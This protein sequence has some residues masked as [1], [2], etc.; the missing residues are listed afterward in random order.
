MKP[1]LAIGDALPA[2]IVIVVDALD[3]CSS[4]GEDVLALLVENAARLPVRFIVTSRPEP[5]IA[6]QMEVLQASSAHRIF[7]LHDIEESFVQE[8]IAAY[9]RHAFQRSTIVTTP[10]D[11]ERLAAYAGSLF[12]VAATTVRYILGHGT[13]ISAS[14]S[15]ERMEAA[16]TMA[17]TGAGTEKQYTTIDSLYKAILERVM[18]QLEDS[19]ASEICQVLWAT[20]CVREP[21]PISTLS[22]I[23]D[24]KEDTVYETIKLLQSVLHV[25]EATR[26]VSTL[27]AS[28]PD[29]MFSKVR[30]G[31]FH[32]NRL[33]HDRR[34]VDRCFDMMAKQLKFNICSIETSHRLDKDIPDLKGRLEE[35]V[36]SE[37]FYAC[38]YWPDHLQIT[39][40]SDETTIPLRRFLYEH[41]L[42]WIEVIN[43]KGWIS[44][45]ADA[46]L[47]ALKWLTDSAPA[48]FS[49]S[50]DLAKLERAIR[51]AQ[52]FVTS[53]A[54]SPVS[55]STPHLYLSSLP[56]SSKHSELFAHHR[57]RFRGLP[58]ELA[59]TRQEA[60]GGIGA[61]AV[62]TPGYSVTSLAVSP[63]GARLASG[64]HGGAIRIWD[65]RL[66]VVILDLV[67]GHPTSTWIS[68]VAFPSS[69]DSL[70]SG[71]LDG[72]ICIWNVA[73]AGVLTQTI[74]QHTGPINTVAFHPNIRMLASASNDGS[75]CLWD[76]HD[77]QQPSL[78]FQF[79]DDSHWD[80]SFSPNGLQLASA[81]YGQSIH[82]RSTETGELMA[83]PLRGHEPIKRVRYTPDGLRIV[84]Y[85][86]DKTVRVWSSHD[87]TL[88]AGPFHLDMD[89][90]SPNAISL[91]PDPQGSLLACAMSDATIQVISTNTG[92]LVSGPFSGHT[93]TIN[94]V[95]FLPT[96]NQLVSASADGTVR[97]WEV[98]RGATQPAI[99]HQGHTMAINSVTVSPDGT[100]VVSGSDDRS[101]CIWDATSGVLLRQIPRAHDDRINSVSFCSDGTKFTSGSSDNTIRIWSPHSG[102]PI[103]H[104]LTGHTDQV[105]T[106]S[107]SS[108]GNQLVSGSDDHTVRV[109][110]LRSDEVSSK[111]LLGHTGWVLSVAFSPDDAWVVSGSED[112]KVGL[113]DARESALIW[114]GSAHTSE[115]N[116]VIFSPD[117]SFVASGSQD[118]M[119]LF[120][121]TCTGAV[122]G[123]PLVGQSLQVHSL[124]FSPDGNTLASGSVHHMISVWDVNTRALRQ[125]FEAYSGVHSVAFL[126]DGRHIISGQKDGS[127]RK[128]DTSVLSGSTDGEAASW[129]AR[130]DGWVNNQKSRLL[131]WLP[132]D[133]RVRMFLDPRNVLAIIGGQA[134]VPETPNLDDFHFGDTWQECY[135]GATA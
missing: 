70:A 13:V 105:W 25:S 110:D 73:T 86:Q 102:E 83:D 54:A 108:N 74:K 53:F 42:L 19:E 80:V 18:E 37:L 122:I 92:Q 27:H 4:G 125:S 21:A 11:I 114:M 68:A 132:H 115:V 118:G 16:L 14:H 67:G 17:R 69:G 55:H 38:R 134:I 24:M 64:S 20:L 127:I 75:V 1:L 120:W 29:F 43:L 61:L 89:T 81:G 31:R 34:L 131:V 82:I 119:V 94:S 96:G 41:L 88:L 128:W 28:F 10:H 78:R 46:M 98:N 62:W 76:L 71:A 59:S 23:V 104:T 85:S 66:G 90:N 130:K 97:I 12:I 2:D 51:D 135:T 5:A 126:P 79:D 58:G 133:L 6:R 33:I 111:Y 36:S 8:D 48:N 112:C 77:R 91:S 52:A 72:S 15:R 123:E 65:A 84:S 7:H 49:S 113:W 50:P 87:G 9:L 26:M 45:A 32:C 116:A 106:V 121:D 109:W 60:K 124:T 129:V 47:Q 57:N 101:I 93:S 44:S 103:G 107:C 56:T 30:A 35:C 100:Q 39:S 63:D 3:E 99:A 22:K 95:H 40:V 117:G